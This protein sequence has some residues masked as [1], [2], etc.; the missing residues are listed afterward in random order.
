MEDKEIIELYF[1]RNQEAISHT[2]Q[3]YGR[4]ARLIANNILKNNEDSEECVQ[5]CYL[6]LWQVIPPKT[7]EK[8]MG[9]IGKIVR[10]LAINKYNAKAAK[11]RGNGEVDVCL[12]EL[13][14]CVGNGQSV[15][16]AVEDQYDISALGNLIN[17]FLRGEN[18]KSKAYFVHRYFMHFS[19]KE[20]AEKFSTSETAVKCNLFRTRKKL[21]NY[22][23]RRGM[24]L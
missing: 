8:F 23:K 3:K 14:E 13:S 19:I 4:L 11:K 9:F 15:E 2:D 5:D 22:L 17:G 24:T 18:S 6:K 12:D 7:P 10:N 1:Q 21:A 20:I 16:K